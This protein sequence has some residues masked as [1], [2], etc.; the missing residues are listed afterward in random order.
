MP[1]L[2]SNAVTLN[3][4]VAD[5]WAG[6]SFTGQGQTKKDLDGFKASGTSVKSVDLA[7]KVRVFGDIVIVTGSHTEKS[8]YETGVFANR[9][10]HW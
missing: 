1:P 5:D 10:G 3:R 7:T 4:I 2:C 8:S 9:N 6:I